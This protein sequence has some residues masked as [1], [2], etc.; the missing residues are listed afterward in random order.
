MINIQN[1]DNNKCFKWCLVRYLHSADCNPPIITKADKDFT[2]KLDC[3]NIKFPVKTRDINKAEEKKRI[4]SALVHSVIKI[5]KNIQS[6]FQK[7]AVKRNMLIY[8][9]LFKISRKS[10]YIRFENHERKTK[11]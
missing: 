9:Y 4:L 2:E 3:K 5:R 1:I 6:M 11:S 7:Y 8:Y 10:K